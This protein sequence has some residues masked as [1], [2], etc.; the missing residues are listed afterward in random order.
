MNKLQKL[1]RFI[2]GLYK[3]QTNIYVRGLL[4]AWSG[5]D[6]LLV[7]AVKDAKEQIFV[8]TARLQYLDA[9][10]SNVGV[11]RPTEINLAD[12]LYRQLIPALSFYPKQVVPTIKKVLDIFF[13]ESSPFVQIKEVKPNE[14]VIQIPST[15]PSL[16][17]DL[18]GSHHFHN[19]TGTIVSIDNALKEI[20]INL[21]DPTKSL[22]VDELIYGVFAQNLQ[23][24]P[25]LSNTAGNSGV[26]LQFDAV[27]D[28][29][30]FTVGDRFNMLLR[31]YPGSFFPDPT[32]SFTVTERRGILGQNISAGSILTSVVM[33]DASGIPNQTGKIIFNFGQNNQ[34]A[35][36]K[37]FGRPNNSTLLIDPL[38]TFVNNHS[39]GEAVNFIVKPYLKP[40]QDG[41]DYSIYLVD[42]LAARLLAQKIVK[43]IVAAG[44]V[45]R[46]IVIEAKC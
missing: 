23:F 33:I 37:Y 10:G 26:I 32:R 6:D 17:R 24:E 19:Y 15:V 9:L 20:Q 36:I 13:G 38:Y 16:R 5:E 8:Q 25:I 34:E 3:P 18:K 4:Y 11:F 43:S 30:K 46:W 22:L 1:Q 40:R 45:I 42:V 12:D 39:V 35:D 14:I 28:L 44:V 41:S 31:N 21:D 7:Q 29:N 27:A 2:P